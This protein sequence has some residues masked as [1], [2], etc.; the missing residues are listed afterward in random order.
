MIEA[1]ELVKTLK[2]QLEHAVA[3]EAELERREGRRVSLNQSSRK[4]LRAC[5]R[6]SYLGRD[7]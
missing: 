1:E 6:T 4:R 2:H 3:V 5:S 7:V